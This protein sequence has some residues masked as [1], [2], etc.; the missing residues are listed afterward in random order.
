LGE[1]LSRKADIVVPAFA[2]VSATRACIESVFQ[3]TGAALGQLI[4][5]NDCSPDAGM[6]P[7]LHELQARHPE[8]ILISNETNLGFVRSANRG[9]GLRQRDVVLLNSDTLV[10]PGWLSEML[11]V[12][13]A[14]DCVAAVVPLS[15]NAAICS[16]PAYCQ[17]TEMREL[18]DRDLEL[19]A[20]PRFTAVPTGVGFCLLLKN[21]VLNMIGGFDPA[22]GR[23][24]HEENDWAM[25]A[26]TLGFVVLRANRA[27]VYHLGAVSFGVEREKLDRTNSNLLL[28]RYPYFLEEVR[29]FSDRAEARIAASYVRRRMGST[30]VC[31]SFRHLDSS[32]VQGA[33]VYPLELAKSLK[34]HAQL[35]VVG[36]VKTPEQERLLAEMGIL[37]TTGTR[38][39][40]QAIFHHP[41]PVSDPED[42]RLFLSARG[43][44]VIT[45]DDLVAWRAPSA[46][47]SI[48]DFEQYVAMCFA[49]LGSAQAVIATSNYNRNEI[50]REFHLPPERV[51]TVYLG[52]DS[53]L[54]EP[55]KASESRSALE[56]LGVRKPF[57]LYVGTDH[58]HQNLKLLLT[59]YAVF[60]HRFH[61][62]TKA[63]PELILIG[64]P[65]YSLGSIYDRDEPWP[66][67]VR[68]FNAVDSGDLRA[69]YRE[70]LAFVF[71]SAAEGSGLPVLEAMA[72]GIPVICSSLTSGPEVA[73]DAALY[74]R[75]FSPEEIAQLMLKA[76]TSADL[77]R[78]LIREGRKQVKKFTCRETARRTA[79][80]YENVIDHPAEVSLL[81]RSM[82]LNLLRAGGLG[83][84]SN[85][86][87]PV[88][89][90]HSPDHT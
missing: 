10:T 38:S 32:R 49:A 71:P 28:E 23:G 60:R 86:S 8:M 21:I 7:M 77:R 79:E 41:G 29:T 2:D 17:A 72:A 16:V 50:L 80:I 9:M 73:G 63:A 52:V 14:H 65:S 27:L 64:A 69:F 61:D 48:V 53:A 62:Q 20:L 55:R 15:N 22:Y 76:S 5:V 54:L 88:E 57:F 39:E 45:F 78:S 74:I 1:I 58:A 31:I 11:E 67:G 34:K 44:L 40:Q 46:H 70:A 24:Y 13:Y 68:Y 87:S 43:H 75:D 82:F 37:S 3:C 51:H 59:A 18:I 66:S 42:L 56:A 85:H 33:D 26:Q 47:R 19:E 6:T 36:L 30:S 81:Q 25:R 4:V 35:E 83:S 12:A 84:I 90:E 89:P